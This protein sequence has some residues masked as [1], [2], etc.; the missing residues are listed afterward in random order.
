MNVERT[1][2][3]EKSVKKIT[4]KVAK[5]RLYSLIEKLEMSHNLNEISNV[6]PIA[7][8]PNIYRIRTGYYRLFVF[9]ID[10]E[11]TILLLEY[12]KKNDNTYRNYN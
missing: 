11:I 5:K 2:E 12:V 8:N 9:Y 6:K 3:F 1:N 10:G 4:D 7:K